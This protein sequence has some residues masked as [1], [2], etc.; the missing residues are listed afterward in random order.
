MFV[1]FLAEADRAQLHELGRAMVAEVSPHLVFDAQ[2]TD[3]AID[4]ALDGTGQCVIVLAGD[5]G[6]VFGFIAAQITDYSTCAGFFV[7]QT[8]FYI[9]P[10]TRGTRAAAGL[11]AAF[12]LWAESLHPEEVFAGITAGSRSDA[13][14][15]WI[16]RFGFEPV[17]QHT[18]RR[19]VDRHSP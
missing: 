13:A 6:E 10:E 9:R 4:R 3:T 14:A 7:A 12:V 2:R 17:G 18:M 19:R 15:R 16:R 11:F 8:L 1:R 5:A